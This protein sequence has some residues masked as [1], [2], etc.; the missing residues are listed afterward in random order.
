VVNV[1]QKPEVNKK[2]EK[3]N[4]KIQIVEK[5]VAKN[6]SLIISNQF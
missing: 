6:K 1:I 5:Q 4:S 3:V 2:E